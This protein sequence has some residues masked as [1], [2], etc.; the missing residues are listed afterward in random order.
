MTCK[1]TLNW[2]EPAE[3]FSVAST[4]RANV[5]N[6]ANTDTDRIQSGVSTATSG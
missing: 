2:T 3:A 1:L 4:V 6:I 5:V